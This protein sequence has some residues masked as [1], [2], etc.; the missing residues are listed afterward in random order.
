M[1]FVKVPQAVFQP[2]HDLIVQFVYLDFSIEL[3]LKLQYANSTM[4]DRI[5]V[6]RVHCYRETLDD[7]SSRRSEHGASPIKKCA[8]HFFF[9]QEFLYNEVLQSR[10]RITSAFRRDNSNSKH[11]MVCSFRSMSISNTAKSFISRCSS[12]S[13]FSTAL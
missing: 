10:N 12:V 4:I 8:D 7:Y 9:L 2:T 13:L 3:I 11:P 6:F 1:V 5:L